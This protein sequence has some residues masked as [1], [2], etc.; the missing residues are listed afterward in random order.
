MQPELLICGLV[1]DLNHPLEGRIQP[2]LHIGGGFFIV[3]TPPRNFNLIGLGWSPVV[4]W[5]IEQNIFSHP[6]DV[7][8]GHRT[9]F[10]QW[11]VTRPVMSRNLT[12]ASFGLS[13]VLQ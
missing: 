10:G 11:S 1:W 6:I 5:T 13:L 7:G 8:L 3:P 9:C 12:R 4:V 2:Q